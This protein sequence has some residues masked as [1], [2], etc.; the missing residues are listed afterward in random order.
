MNRPTPTPDC[1]PSERA[2]RLA[3]LEREHAGLLANLPAHSLPPALL[4]R[5]EEIEEA[6]AALRRPP[7]DDESSTSAGR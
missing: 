7:S 4:M 5:L 6:I 3:A 1:F 2:V